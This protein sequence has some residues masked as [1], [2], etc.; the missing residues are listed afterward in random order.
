MAKKSI[1]CWE[2]LE[3]A[4]PELKLL[5]EEYD[6]KRRQ[7]DEIVTHVELLCA[8]IPEVEQLLNVK[9]LGLVSIAGI[10]AETGTLR[11]FDSPRYV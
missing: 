8:Q 1:G 7:Y 4:G 6:V 11:R 5:L 2:G 3:A 10:L 9:E